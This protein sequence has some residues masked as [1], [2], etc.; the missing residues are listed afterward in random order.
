MLKAFFHFCEKFALVVFFKLVCIMITIK[1]SF[2]EI[3]CVL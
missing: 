2:Q 1:F 3:Q